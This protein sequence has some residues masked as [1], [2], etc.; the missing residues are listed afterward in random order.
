MRDYEFF[1]ITTPFAEC[2]EKETPGLVQGW[3]EV[4]R[5]NLK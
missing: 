1:I 4:F 5:Q 3:A 2:V